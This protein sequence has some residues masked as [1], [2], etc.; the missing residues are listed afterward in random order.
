MSRRDANSFASTRVINCGNNVSGFSLIVVGE[1]LKLLNET[2]VI[3]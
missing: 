2:S 3:R 1:C